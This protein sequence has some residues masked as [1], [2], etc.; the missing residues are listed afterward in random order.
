MS[1]S[2]QGHGGVNQLGGV[3]VNGRPLPDVVRQRIVELAQSGVRPCDISRQL[4]VS[5]GCVSKILCRFYETGSIKPGVIG[6]SKPKVATGNVVTKIAE[7]KLA[8]PTMFAWEIRDRLLSEGVCTSDNVPSVSSINRIVRNRINS[9]DKMSNPKGNPGDNSPMD[10][11][12]KSDRDMQA[13]NVP[14]SSY[15]I[16]GLLGI[17]M[18][19]QQVAQHTSPSKRKYSVDSADSTGSHSG[20]EGDDPNSQRSK[21]S[22]R[23]RTNFTDEQIEK[24]EKVFEKTHY[25][26]V[27]TREELAQQVNLS[28]ARIQV[29]YSNRRAKWRKEGKDGPQD[30]QGPI[31]T[32]YIS[33]NGYSHPSVISPSN[34]QMNP[35][36]VEADHT[37]VH[38]PPSSDQNIHVKRELT[39]LKPISEN[40]LG[41]GM[42]TIQQNQ[43]FTSYSSPSPTTYI[44]VPTTGSGGHQYQLQPIFSNISGQYQMQNP[45]TTIADSETT[46]II[47]G[48]P[49]SS[50]ALSPPAAN[51]APGYVLPPVSTLTNKGH[52]STQYQ[53]AQFAQ[54]PP[55]AYPSSDQWIPAYPQ[56]FIGR[57]ATVFAVPAQWAAPPPSSSRIQSSKLTTS[58]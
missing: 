17:P 7:Y 53:S 11:A 15:S 14:R 25:P 58:A 51:T 47:H 41:M 43:Q 52:D 44:S 56:G 10:M 21:M 1:H 54:I 9:Q 23:Q 30:P 19:H 24:L 31:Q 32:T 26:D 16:S 6:G 27:F 8:N 50:Q 49:A 36:H 20:D 37:Q 45:I 57:P 55:G 5:H 29:W 12:L 4:R 13:I 33:S 48:N 35:I 2:K 22:R 18:P 40:S 42:P 46:Q 38:Y 39:E 34:M 28:E 3:F